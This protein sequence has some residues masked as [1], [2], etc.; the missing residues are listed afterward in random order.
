MIDSVVV[1]TA[2]FVGPSCMSVKDP[3][4]ANRPIDAV[5]S[6]DRLIAKSQARITQASC[7]L[8]SPEHIWYR[9]DSR[10]PLGRSKAN[11]SNITLNNYV[12]SLEQGT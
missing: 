3:I 2:P 7:A 5:T 9:L 1:A 10:I 11:D 4:L 6:F 12:L 8:F